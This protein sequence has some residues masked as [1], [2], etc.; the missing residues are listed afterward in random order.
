VAVASRS[1]LEERGREALEVRNRRAGILGIG[2]DC[3]VVRSGVDVLT[4]APGDRFLV[5]PGH[6][7][8]DEALAAATG[9]VG[10][11]VSERSELS[12]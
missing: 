7:R 3:D 10:I 11:V 9:D 12:T 2:L 5:A 1:E 4:H 6:D 8:V